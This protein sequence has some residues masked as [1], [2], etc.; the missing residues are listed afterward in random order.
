MGAMQGTHCDIKS[1]Y[2]RSSRIEN[3]LDRGKTVASSGLIRKICNGV[4]MDYLRSGLNRSVE[5]SLFTVSTAQLQ[6]IR[7]EAFFFHDVTERISAHRE[8]HGLLRSGYTPLTMSRSGADFSSV[9]SG[10]DVRFWEKSRIVTE[11]ISAATNVTERCG[12][13]KPLRGYILT[14]YTSL[15]FTDNRRK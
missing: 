12:L 7:C 3:N 5:K 6:S 8:I 2:D 13:I 10:S 4:G 15:P 9:R 11:R 14:P 1:F